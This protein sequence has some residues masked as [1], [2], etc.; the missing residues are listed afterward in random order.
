MPALGGVSERRDRRVGVAS[1]Q[2]VDAG[3]QRLLGSV[4]F[5]GIFSDGSDVDPSNAKAGANP[6]VIDPM[7]A[8]AKR[9][10]NDA[11]STATSAHATTRIRSRPPSGRAAVPSK[12]LAT[13]TTSVINRF[14]TA[15][16]LWRNR[17][18]FQPESRLARVAS[19]LL[20][21]S[22]NLALRA[23]LQTRSSRSRAP[24]SLTSRA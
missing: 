5:F 7:I 10:R 23:P 19:E 22:N 13:R 14:Q 3:A 15:S 6:S 16:R 11:L 9:R 12:A 17:G 1:L 24:V 20:R 2:I 21:K 8:K 4:K 18:A